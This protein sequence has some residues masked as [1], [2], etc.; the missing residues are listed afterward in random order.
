MITFA[1]LS[2]RTLGV[3]FPMPFV[4]PVFHQIKF[5]FNLFFREGK[6]MHLMNQFEATEF[7][8]QIYAHSIPHVLTHES[9]KTWKLKL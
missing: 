8:L 1:P 3:S 2:A 9:N 6:M 4:A 5:I 7:S